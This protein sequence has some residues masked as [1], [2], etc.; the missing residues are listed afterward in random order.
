MYIQVQYSL[1]WYRVRTVLLGMEAS[2]DGKVSKGTGVEA[3]GLAG[4]G[5]E[6]GDMTG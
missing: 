1:D 5:M 6:Q 3:R 4:D 2:P